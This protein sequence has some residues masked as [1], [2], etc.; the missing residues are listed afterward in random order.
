[1]GMGTYVQEITKARGIGSPEVGVIGMSHPLSM[2]GTKFGS[3]AKAI[4]FLNHLL[5]SS[6]IS[7]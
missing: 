4:P 6:T 3:S 1:M 2:L 7:Y 5:I